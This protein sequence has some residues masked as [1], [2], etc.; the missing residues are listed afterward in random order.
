MKKYTVVALFV[1]IWGC[2]N[3][4]QAQE[5]AE[6]EKEAPRSLFLGID[7]NDGNTETESLKADARIK[8]ENPGKSETLLHAVYNYGTVDDNTSADNA[9][10]SAQYNCLSP[11]SFYAFMLLT[12]GYDDIA[13][14][15]Y[16]ATVGPG[17]GKYLAKN[18]ITELA[19]EFGPTYVWEEVGGVS[20]DY[21]AIR[22]AER[23][24]RKLS[25]TAKLFQ[26]IECY[27]EA[28]DTDNY[29][30]AA[31]LGVE[32]ALNSKMNLRVVATDKYDNE[33]AA[34]KDE[35]DL[36]ISAGLVYNF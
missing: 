3:V 16:R 20:D 11:E 1:G 7:L 30:F 28:E 32:A 15:D 36:S 25:E 4:A 35:N 34:G 9:L 23:F 12:G 26:S 19:I 10:A 17:I 31:E 2:F 18:D 5:A 6:A 14:V 22:V 21:L 33:P 8:L 13:D 27:T 29:I 24:S